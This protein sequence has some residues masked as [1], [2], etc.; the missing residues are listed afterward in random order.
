VA[1]LTVVLVGALAAPAEG[2]T[3]DWP[4][5]MAGPYH[6]GWNKFESQ[7]TPANAPA[8]R[9]AWAQP[10]LSGPYGPGSPVIVGS[11]VVVGGGAV[12][13]HDLATGNLLWSTTLTGGVATAPAWAGDTIVVTETQATAPD[14]FTGVAALDAATGA[15]KWERQIAGAGYSSPSVTGDSVL[16]SYNSGVARLRLSDG[17]LVWTVPL[18]GL[19]GTVSSPTTDGSRVYV[20]DSEATEVTALDIDSG[21]IVWQRPSGSNGG[22]TIEAFPP[23]LIHGVLYAPFVNMVVAFKAATGTEL[24]R[25]PI[26]TFWWGLP[27]DGVRVIGVADRTQ[28]IA[29]AAATGKR[30]WAQN[31]TGDARAAALAGGVALVA[32]QS[33]TGTSQLELFDIA[34]GTKL[35]VIALPS[36]APLPVAVSNGHVAVA[37]WEQLVVLTLPAA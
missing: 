4:Q 35:G 37:T 12:T 22:D 24:W 14:A 21:A 25:R 3:G 27:T 32:D 36:W 8:L 33:T 15:V 7:I 9:Q 6:Q 1:F 23:A 17:S 20:V 11:T 31:L 13:A 19:P 34:T 5:F 29:L 18:G 10:I 2:R 16:V 28:L 30:L 26:G